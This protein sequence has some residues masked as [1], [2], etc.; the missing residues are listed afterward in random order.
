M[1]PSNGVVPSSV[2]SNTGLNAIDSTGYKLTLAYEGDTS[3]LSFSMDKTDQDN[4]PPFAQLMYTI[5]NWSAAF[6]VGASA[7]AGGL[8]IAPIELFSSPTRL[9]MQ[10]T[11]L[12]LM[13]RQLLRELA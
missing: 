12:E 13:K 10:A 8:K 3:S 6:G 4:V 9:A 7:A 11:I 1:E 2:S 5:P